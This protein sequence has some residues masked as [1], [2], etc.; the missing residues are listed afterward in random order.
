MSKAS[1]ADALACPERSEGVLC[2]FA[3]HQDYFIVTLNFASIY[4]DLV[5]SRSFTVIRGF[6]AIYRDWQKTMHHDPSLSIWAGY[7]GT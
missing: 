2:F 6:A 1:R 3:R 7:D 4:L 5:L